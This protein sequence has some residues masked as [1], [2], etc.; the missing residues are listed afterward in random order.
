MRL[1]PAGSLA[2]QLRINTDNFLSADDSS[3]FADRQMPPTAGAVTLAGAVTDKILRGI[4]YPKKLIT[5][6]RSS[7]SWKAWLV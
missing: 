5:A 7:L 2:L 6:R 4:C 3:V 1:E